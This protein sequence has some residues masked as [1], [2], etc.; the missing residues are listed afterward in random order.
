MMELCPRPPIQ[1]KAKQ[2]R[3]AKLTVTIDGELHDR[4]MKLYD[5]GYSISHI[6]DS[7]LWQ[8]FDKPPLSFQIDQGSQEE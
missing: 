5:Q 3:R 7:A 1:K 8:L 2:G 6:V 4:L